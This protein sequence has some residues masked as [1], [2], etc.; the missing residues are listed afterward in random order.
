MNAYSDPG[1]NVPLMNELLALTS[2]RK[3]PEAAPDGGHDI[4]WRIGIDDDVCTDQ[5]GARSFLAA[6][7]E[8][9]FDRLAFDM[10]ARFANLPVREV[11]KELE[12]GLRQVCEFMQLDRACLWRKAG[13]GSGSFVLTQCCT[14]TPRTAA[15]PG[16]CS[17]AFEDLFPWLAAQVAAGRTVALGS[18]QDLPL[19]AAPD[20]ESLAQWSAKS[21]AIIPLLVAGDVSGV[22]SFDMIEQSRPWPA[23]LVQR[24]EFTAEVV[25]IGVARLIQDEKVREAE[26]ALQKFSVEIKVLKDRLDGEKV[27][28]QTETRLSQTHKEIVGRGSAIVEVL[29]QVEQVAPVDCTVLI[30][31]ETGSGKELIARAIHRLSSRKDRLMLSVN[32]AAMPATLVE[33]E[34]FGRER[35]AFT[36][37]LTSQV[38]RFEAADGSTV[39]LDEIGELS[40]ETQAKLL[41]VLQE[42]EFERLGSPKTHKVNVRVIVATNKDLE[43]EVQQGRFRRDLYYR[44]SVFPIHVPPLRERVED[45][46]SLVSAFVAEFSSRMSKKVSQIPQKSLELL[47]QHPW[48]GNIREL[49]NIIERGMILSNSGTLVLPNLGESSTLP[50]NP[51]SLE[52]VEREH[53]RKILGE[54]GWRVKGPYGAAKRLQVNP[55][56]LYSRMAKLGIRRPSFQDGMT[57]EGR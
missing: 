39:F 54:T 55:S 53:I 35:G 40:P 43:K 19:A 2:T 30:T 27:P 11:E 22:L 52:D 10:L 37:A 17:K 6:S 13:V 57:N 15:E 46:P 12:R 25:A 31:G 42:G 29:R 23:F 28:L 48:P 1:L 26:Q 33:S 49:R 21:S 4:G 34:L 24:L 7:R 5:A 20:R 44:L 16:P 56:T 38:G 36:G 14:V 9:E 18:Q 41:R 8:C 3:A 50:L 51:T 45:I 47:Q 32:C